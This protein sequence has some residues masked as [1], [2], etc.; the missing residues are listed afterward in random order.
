VDRS[1]GVT[2]LV[3][4]GGAGSRL[5]YDKALIEVGGELLVLRVAR[6]LSSVA[7]PVLLAPGRPGRLGLDHGYSEVTD[8]VPNAGPL[9]GLAAGLQASPHALMAVVA[10]DMPFASPAL[11]GLLAER[12]AGQDAVVPVTGLGVEPLHAMYST[13]ALPAVRE[14]LARERYALRRLLAGLQVLEIPEREWRAAD[15]SGRFAANLN[16]A[17]DLAGLA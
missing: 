1:R 17:E 9:G 6:L 4:C 2:G 8:A 11:F 10:V 5:G 13:S 14:A 7:D 12:W 3:V 15:P 16:R